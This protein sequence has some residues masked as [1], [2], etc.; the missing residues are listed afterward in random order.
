MYPHQ[1]PPA[2]QPDSCAHTTLALTPAAA[3]GPGTAASLLVGSSLYMQAQ[4]D[5]CAWYGPLDCATVLQGETGTGKYV[6][7]QELHRHY[8]AARGGGRR[9]FIRVSGAHLTHGAIQAELHGHSDQAFSGAKRKRRGLIQE[10][11][12][13][14]LYWDEGDDTPGEAQGLALDA[15]DRMA[16]RAMGESRA[17]V[18]EIR[19]IFA[20]HEPL[21]V[22]VAAGKVRRD[23]A[24]RINVI[25]IVLRPLREH[26]ED[27]PELAERFLVEWAARYRWPVPMIAGD[28]MELLLAY[29]WPENVRELGTVL[30]G[31]FIQAAR[32]NLERPVI[33]VHHLPPE[34]LPRPKRRTRRVDVEAFRIE[35]ALRL[36]GG[37][38]RRAAT[39]LGVGERTLQRRIVEYG[40]D[41][42]AFRS[43]GD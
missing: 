41:V 30:E 12:G 37:C 4:R 29:R 8:E 13:G 42:A 15:L 43:R 19:V 40:I 1:R 7:A 6:V 27:V 21:R 39:A 38:V 25:T 33:G 26:V 9:P 22:L 23:L 16:V 2:D 34:V 5:D 35:A 11:S 17:S 10:A 3:G 31:S 14:T 36:S 32:S 28:A 20:V 18:A 24:A